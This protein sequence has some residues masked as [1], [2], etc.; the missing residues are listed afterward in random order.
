MGHRWPTHYIIIGEKYHE[1]WSEVKVTR[2]T[3]FASD[4]VTYDE[5]C[6]MITFGHIL[7]MCI[8]CVVIGGISLI[9]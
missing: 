9:M 2:H 5:F 4:D 3:T 1:Y 6:K 8:Y 7:G